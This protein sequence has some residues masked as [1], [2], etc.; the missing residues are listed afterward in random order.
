MSK[1]IKPGAWETETNQWGG[2]RRFRWVGNTK[3]YETEVVT[4]HG[5]YTQ[6]QID[7]GT[8]K[9]KTV[10]PEAKT[11]SKYCPFK[12]G[13]RVLCRKDCAFWSESGCMQSA[14]TEGKKCPLSLYL[15]GDSCKLFDNGC[16]L[17][18]KGK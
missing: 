18:R 16:S 8:S 17:V 1:E 6:S 10:A 14:D 12:S 5:T 7:K 3:E 13:N 15:C 11:D 4:T 2:V 9:P